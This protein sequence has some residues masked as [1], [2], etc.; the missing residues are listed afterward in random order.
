LIEGYAAG[1]NECPPGVKRATPYARPRVTT[2]LL[3][4]VQQPA[5]GV[6]ARRDLRLPTTESCDGQSAREKSAR[7]TS[8]TG[9][10]GRWAWGIPRPLGAA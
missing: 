10:G 2:Q 3:Q 4:R 8:R 9:Q 6:T 1:Y 7:T 5:T